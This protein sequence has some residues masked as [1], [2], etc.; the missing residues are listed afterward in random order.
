MMYARPHREE[1]QSSIL[2]FISSGPCAN[3]SD[4]FALWFKKKK[5]KSIH[6]FQGPF[7]TKL[8]HLQDSDE[9]N[10]VFAKP[11][12]WIRSAYNNFFFFP[13]NIYSIDVTVRHI[14]RKNVFVSFDCHQSDLWKTLCCPEAVWINNVVFFSLNVSPTWQ[15]KR[16]QTLLYVF[17]K[18][19]LDAALFEV[20]MM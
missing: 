1:K 5:K 10:L 18:Q 13:P 19:S 14:M 16:L 11:C 3:E 20:F 9:R 6:T 8:L 12:M 17:L 7:Y 2:L 4:P 15:E